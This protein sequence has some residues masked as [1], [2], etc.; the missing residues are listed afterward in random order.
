MP[1]LLL[2]TDIAGERRRRPAD[3][4]HPVRPRPRDAPPP[5]ARPRRRRRPGA[6]GA[7]AR[8][9]RSGTSTRAT[10]R[11]CS[12][13]APASYVAA[14]RDARRR[15]GRGPREQ[16]L[17]DPHAGLG[18]QRAVRRRPRPARRR[19]AAR[20]R[21]R[22]TR[23][24]S[25]SSAS[26]SSGWASTAT[27]SQFDMTAFSL[28]LTNGA[29]AVSQLH[30]ETANAT[31]QGVVAA[32]DPR[33]HQRRPR[34]DLDRRSRSRELLERYLGA[35]LDDLDAGGRARPLLGA[36][37]PDPG[38]RAVGGAPAPEARARDLRPRP[39]AQPVRPPRRGAGG[40]SPSSRRALDPDDP[41][42]RLRP[43]VRDL[44][45]GRRCCSATSTGWP[46]M[47]WD[48]ERPDPDRLRRQGPPGRP[49]RPAGHPGDLQRS[50][51]PAAP[52][53]GLHPRGLRH[54]DRAASS[55]RASTS[56]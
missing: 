53:P 22:P 39:A 21:R 29:N 12:P 46:R 43:P 49:A 25:R 11:S 34:P 23:A 36:H 13:S 20:R 4:P 37:R 44:Q 38:R 47:L 54:P 41:D 33:H 5:G 19:P 32:R 28:R 17:H 52:R 9:R 51:S 7:R 35:D 15:L 16:R 42:D 6:A 1:V 2:D 56:G 10:R 55:S 45:A 30:A 50:R 27:R 3:H 18:R 24:A 8:R 14:G 31:W 40:R 48:E 26:S